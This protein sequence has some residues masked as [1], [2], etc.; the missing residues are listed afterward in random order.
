MRSEVTSIPNPDTSDTGGAKIDR[1]DD[2]FI[3]AV[4]SIIVFLI[5]F[6]AGVSYCCFRTKRNRGPQVS[7]NTAEHGEAGLEEGTLNSCPVITYAEAKH[8]DARSADD[9]CCSVCLADYGE[10]DELRMLPQCGHLFHVQCVDPWLRLQ[11]KCPLCRSSI[12]ADLLTVSFEKIVLF[13]AWDWVIFP[14]SV[15]GLLDVAIAI[16]NV[17]SHMCRKKYF[18]RMPKAVRDQSCAVLL[19]C[20]V[21]QLDI[22]GYCGSVPLTWHILISPRI[23]FCVRSPHKIISPH[24][25][26]FY[27]C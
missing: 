5:V 18:V 4:S 27:T 23:I 20:S 22:A 2:G 7:N 14:G 19:M 9:S 3:I 13:L 15:S 8:Q 25:V 1:L 21:P 26:T 17:T 10:D 11:P 6:I 24:A 16:T 12:Y